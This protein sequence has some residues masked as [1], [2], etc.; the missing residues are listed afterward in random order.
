M[1]ENA[2]VTIIIVAENQLQPLEVCLNLVRFYGRNMDIQVLVADNG[3]S[4]G[5]SQWLQDNNMEYTCFGHNAGLGK[6]LNEMLSRYHVDTDVLLLNP[7]YMLTDG[8]L[9]AMREVLYGEDRIGAV[10]PISNGF[11]RCSLP[12]YDYDAAANLAEELK[13][14]PGRRKRLGLYDGCVL[15]KYEAMK[16]VGDF[17]EEFH[18]AFFVILDYMIRMLYE[19]YDLM[20]SENAIAYSI[21]PYEECFDEK[22]KE[23]LNRKYGM[24]YFN[25]ECNSFIVEQIE[26]EENKTLTVL[27]IGC[28]CGATLLEITNKFPDAHVYGYEI[29]K[30]AASV[31]SY[32]AEVEVGNIEKFEL[33]Y[34][35][36]FFQYIL[37]PDVLEHLSKPK[38]VLEYL[39]RFLREDGKIIINIPNIQ[40]ISV[41]R[42]LLKGNFTYRESG[43]LDETHIHFF[44]INE[45]N[46]MLISIGYTVDLIIS[47]RSP[48]SE[49]DQELIQK[50]V[51]IMPGAEKAMFEAFQYLL[52]VS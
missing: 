43:L 25:I 30:C 28:D 5:T 14:R 9:E 3:S 37:L 35:Q 31:A 44:T 18:A 15:L 27:E 8:C 36:G 1:A 2:K 22:E 51:G 29:N 17:S 41:V 24:K 4:D 23:L 21:S 32:A 50:L 38:E 34:R 45:I 40:H 12:V 46:R 13:D 7:D 26:K 19:D 6:I 39:K 42:E 11:G 52:V 47:E 33:P 48:L 16:R 49:E 20:S 10:N